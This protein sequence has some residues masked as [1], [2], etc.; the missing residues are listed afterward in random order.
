VGKYYFL[1]RFYLF[2]LPGR[3]ISTSGKSSLRTS[4]VSEQIS[5][6]TLPTIGPHQ[7]QP[8][9]THWFGAVATGQRAVFRRFSRWCVIF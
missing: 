6:P 2:K 8:R 7:A 9:K 5:A 1:D 3:T 4:P